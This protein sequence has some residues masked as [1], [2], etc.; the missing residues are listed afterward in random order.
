MTN[1]SN[2]AKLTKTYVEKLQPG[3]SSEHY[4]DSELAGFGIR[5]SPGGPKTYIVQG[6]V[7]STGKERR[8]S[9]GRHGVF[10]PDQARNEARELLRTM[11]LG[12]DPR[13]L[14]RQE[15]V[16][17]V[18]LIEVAEAYWARPGMLK[19]RTIED[20]RRYV[21]KHLAPFKNRPIASINP[22]DVRKRYDELA[23]KG[24]GG[25]PAPTQAGNAMVCLKALINFAISEYRDAEGRPLIQFNAVSILKRELAQN[26]P[27]TRHVD[28]RDVGTFWHG[29]QQS[30]VTAQ[31]RD[32]LTG[33]HLV[34][35]LLLT[36][37][38]RNEAAQ[39]TWDRVHLDDEDPS[40]CWWH[41]PTPKNGNPVWLP[42]SSQAVAVLREREKRSARSDYV[43]R[44]YKSAP[45]HITDTRS[46][47]ERAAKKLGME[48]LSAHDLRRSFVTIGANACRLD[49]SKVALLTNHVLSG[50]TEKYYLQNKDLRDYLPE[51]QAIGDFIEN[52]GR[53]AAAKATGGNVV[54]LRA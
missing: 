47:L 11:R 7:S 40:N 53:I 23:T 39:L 1:K 17:K 16:S 29:L 19:P 41:L 25:K 21:H 33:I 54:S 46:P 24:V 18:S 6:R 15:A 51:V 22:A 35:F 49:I 50:V 3:S 52:E 2:R 4:W 5:V 28:R 14:Q 36:G 34:E 48:R 44:S 12:E 26:A 9:I 32:A 20:Q 42:L 8:I 13:E 43:F 30:K 37:A 31:D 38:R 10:S 45:G 27:R